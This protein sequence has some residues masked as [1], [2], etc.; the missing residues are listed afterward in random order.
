MGDNS[1]IYRREK[2]HTSKTM[3]EVAPQK[4]SHIDHLQPFAMM[5]KPAIHGAMAGAAT[6]HVPQIHSPYGVLTILVISV[7]DTAPV[8]RPGD[9]KKP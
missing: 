3:H 2:K 4:I 6:A 9:P 8:A 7:K 1:G 5:L